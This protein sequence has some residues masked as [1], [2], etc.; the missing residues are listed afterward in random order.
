MSESPGRKLTAQDL[1]AVILAG[2]AG[3]RIR[4]LAPNVPK[5]MITVLGRP[6]IEWIVRY[7]ADQGIPRILISTGFKAE[8]VE[9]HFKAHPVKGVTIGCVAE[10]EP[11]G[12]AGGFLNAVRHSNDQPKGWLVLNGDSMALAPL[13]PLIE[14]LDD[15]ATS[16]AL[17]G[18]FVSDAA[19]FGT[20]QVG[21]QNKLLGF[22]EKREGAGVINA[23]VYL[24]R[25]EVLQL[26]SDQARLSFELDVFPKL[27]ARDTALKVSVTNAPF[28]DIG[29]P[30]TLPLAENFLRTA[31]IPIHA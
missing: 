8:I 12:T 30:E 23:G 28:L 7:L 13:A 18:V 26:F 16:G 22:L 3:T 19:R 6:F 27:A 2:G 20:L 21:A 29:T 9:E 24:F 4:H 14:L 1:T 10:G 11:L 5:P 15:P 17:L 31:G 25:P